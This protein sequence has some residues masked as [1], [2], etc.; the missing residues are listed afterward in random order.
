M[1]RK[2]KH[3][4][5]AVD[6]VYYG[7]VDVFPTQTAFLERIYAMTLKEDADHAFFPDWKATH[8]L[9]GF[10]QTETPKV[11]REWHRWAFFEDGELCLEDGSPGTKGAFELWVWR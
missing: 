10:I 9:P 4:F 5:W 7:R 1:P 11:R 2:P 6:G 3:K 8:P